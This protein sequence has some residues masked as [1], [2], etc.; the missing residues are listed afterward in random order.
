MR[1]RPRAVWAAV[2]RLGRVPLSNQ[3]TVT[4]PFLAISRSFSVSGSPSPVYHLLVEPWLISSSFATPFCVV[5]SP[6]GFHASANRPQNSDGSLSG[7][8]I[9]GVCEKDLAL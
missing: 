8:F 6:R 3:S 9:S 5:G 4:S 1:N 2:G 7:R